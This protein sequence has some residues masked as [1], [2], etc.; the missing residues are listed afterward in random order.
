MAYTFLTNQTP[1][2]AAVAIYN[3]KTTFKA[4]GWTV[5]RSS[6]GTT[7]NNSGDQI[8]AGTSG[9]GGMDNARAWFVIQEPAAP[10]RQY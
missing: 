4:A 3:L 7:Y 5:P 6:D 1:A 10:S 2:T 9:A 8:S